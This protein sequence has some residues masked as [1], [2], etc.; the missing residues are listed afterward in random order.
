MRLDR[1]FTKKK[2]KIWWAGKME[3]NMEKVR[4]GGEDKHLV[5][6]SHNKWENK[7]EEGR[8][9]YK[10]FFLKHIR[11]TKSNIFHQINSIFSLCVYLCLCPLSFYLSVSLPLS[12]WKHSLLWILHRSRLLSDPS[13]PNVSLDSI[14][15]EHNLVNFLGAVLDP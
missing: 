9:E 4:E 14:F 11:Q 7:Y 12:L 6:F 3:L 2:D 8:H 10:I 5:E 1:L 13:F 15:K